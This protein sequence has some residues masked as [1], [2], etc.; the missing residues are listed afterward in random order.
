MHFGLRELLFVI[1]LIAMPVSSY[2]YVFRPQNAE[3]EQAKKEIEHKEQML[4]KL[5]TATARNED[6]QRANEE[7]AKGI[8]TIESRLPDDKEIEVVLEQ[9]ATLARKTELDLSK[10][11]TRRAVQAAGYM[12]QP[13]EMTMRGAFGDFY[14]FLLKLEEMPRITRMPNLKVKKL[15]EVDGDMETTFTLAIYFEPIGSGDES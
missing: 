13:L 3:I 2:W 14:T 7:I 6:L 5:H 4:E 8:E 12:E 9:V 1:V 15:D 11:R 10:V